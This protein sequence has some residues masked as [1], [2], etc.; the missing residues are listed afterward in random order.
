[1]RIL[2]MS[3][4]YLYLWPAILSSWWH[5]H[6]CS[7][8]IC[9][10]FQVINGECKVYYLWPS[11]KIKTVFGTVILFIEFIIPFIILI[12]CYGKIV[13]MLSR[14]IN[15]GMGNVKSQAKK[16]ENKNSASDK[17][18]ITDVHKDKF[19]LARRNTIKTVLIVG[20]CF[21][22]CWSQNE[23]SYLMYNFGYP[24]ERNST[25]YKF[26]ILM[27]FCNCTVNPFIYLIQHH[28]YQVAVRQFL[29]CKTMD[30]EENW[31]QNSISIASNQT[32]LTP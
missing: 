23:F 4:S 27:V 31:S 11:D 18:K 1:M 14:R 7:P 9:F 2:S 24:I 25:Y 5:L 19:Q 15:T 13:W 30:K 22:I 8:S 3:L 16:Y 21:I 28:D 32:D 17:D 20:L 12:F 6:P 10:C 29:R 26:T